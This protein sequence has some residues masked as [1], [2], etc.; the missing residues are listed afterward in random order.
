MAVE[1]GPGASLRYWAFLS[2]AHA[3]SAAATRL[4]R[5]LEHYTLPA[6][7][8]RAHRLPKRLIPVFRDLEELEASASLTSRL[9][10]ALD[11]SRW[12]IVLCSEASAR[13]TYVNAE[14]EYFVSKHGPERILCVLLDGDPPSV[15][16]AALRDQ[17]EEPLAADLRSGAAHDVG[18]LKLVAAMAVVNFTEL[19]DREAQ[20]RQRRQLAAAAVG[21]GAL[22]GTALYWDLFIREHVTYYDKFVRTDG[23]WTGVDRISRKDASQRHAS[24]RFLRSGRLNPPSRVDR[25]NGSGH[26]TASGMADVLGQHSGDEWQ[27]RNLR[28]CSA[29][30][31][32]ARDGSIRAE[33]LLNMFGDPLQSLSYTEPDLAQFT[34]EGFAAANARSGIYYV[35]FE[36]DRLGRDIVM[37]FLHSRGQPRPDDRKAFGYRMQYDARGRETRRS[38]LDADGNEVGP[39]T[40]N[41]YDARGH[42]ARTRFEDIDGRPRVSR[43]GVAR[44]EWQY[45]EAGNPIGVAGFD[46]DGSPTAN[47]DRWARVTYAYDG[48]GNRVREA[49][50]D[51]QGLPTWTSSSEGT[52]V[53]VSRFDDRGDRIRVEG[54]SADGALTEGFGGSA[55]LVATYDDRGLLVEAAELDRHER[56]TRNRNGYAIN[57]FRYDDRGNMVDQDFLDPDGRPT[58]TRWGARIRL[59]YDERSN[60]VEWAFFD[61]EGRRHLRPDRGAAVLSVDR[62]ERGNVVETRLLDSDHDLVSG[63]DGHAILRYRYDDFGNL[64]ELRHFDENGMPVIN[65]EGYSV[66]R[67]RFDAG[68]NEIERRHYDDRDRPASVGDDGH[69]WNAEYD[70]RGRLLRRRHVDATGSPH[71]GSRGYAAVRFEYDGSGVVAAEHYEEGENGAPPVSMAEIVRDRYDLEVERRYRDAAGDLVIGPDGFAILQTERDPFGNELRQS[72]LGTD[73]QPVNRRGGGWATKTTRYERGVAVE[74][75]FHDRDGRRIES[76]V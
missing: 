75:I 65:A 57:R 69:G 7:V 63:P 55:V 3:D 44:F 36:R 54:R 67:S 51:A 43:Q 71:H 45:D 31:S 46:A 27:S 19:R 15:F 50:F 39:V 66:R 61:E 70:S 40:V 18:V 68:G 14:V 22:L 58:R 62:D 2:Y 49:Y 9:Q 5:E 72:C 41:E 56:P 60:I 59:R 73:L 26:C 29:R 52:E 1:H 35:H 4:H 32:Y 30:F 76:G 8:R 38:P 20:R 34:R 12:L 16:P 10:A 74:R 33:R 17:G 23:I 25:T 37:H 64:A 47:R 11:E 13:S 21:A 53:L 28:I 24:Y 42:L 48:R 6:S